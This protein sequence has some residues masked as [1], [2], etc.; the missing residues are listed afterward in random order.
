M[1]TTHRRQPQK[2]LVRLREMALIL[3]VTQRWLRAEAKS[4][5]VPHLKAEQ[6]YLFCP[7]A[8]EKFLA[9]RASEVP[10]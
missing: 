1:R 4:K 10:A 6:H 9:A 3:G 2:K 5:R 8:T 7:A